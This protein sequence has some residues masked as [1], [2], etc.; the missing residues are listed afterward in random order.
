MSENTI[1]KKMIIEA[2]TSQSIIYAIINPIEKKAYIGE[3]SDSFR[4]LSEHIRGI[5]FRDKEMGTNENLA[6]ENCRTFHFMTLYSRNYDKHNKDTKKEINEWILYETIYMYLFK[7]SGFILYNGDN[8]QQDNLG[9]KRAFLLGN[10][11]LSETLLNERMNYFL[12]SGTKYSD[13]KLK[14]IWHKIDMC[15][16]SLDKKIKF[17][18]GVTLETLRKLDRRKTYALWEK[19]YGFRKNTFTMKSETKKEDKDI[20]YVIDISPDNNI[21]YINKLCEISCKISRKKLVKDELKVL[22]LKEK[23]LLEMAEAGVLDKIIVS[24]IG[25]Y[26]GQSIET[27][28]LTKM[29]DIYHNKLREK[30]K[31]DIVC[32]DKVSR[33]DGICFWSLK[34]LPLDYTRDFIEKGV[35]ES[36][37][38]SFYVIMPYVDSKPPKEFCVQ[39]NDLKNYYLLNP[40]DNEDLETFHLRIQDKINQIQ[41]DKETDQLS[42]KD[43]TLL[44]ILASKYAL[45]KE[46]L[47]SLNAKDY[48][49]RNS[50]MFPE[51]LNKKSLNVAFLVSELS[52][53]KEDF[54]D[55]EFYKYFLSKRGGYK[56][57]QSKTLFESIGYSSCCHMCAELNQKE[58]LINFLKNCSYNSKFTGCIIAK[59]EYPYIVAIK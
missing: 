22:N 59:I 7:K 39:E 53:S 43:K 20:V 10:E 16:A 38:E 26:L 19:K 5:G 33:D 24:K 58:N 41:A 51:V 8:R 32:K 14:E 1:T 4:R 40:H 29:Y 15:S 55:K 35:M 13:D 46:D 27:I 50:K 23:S 2:P 54:D 11:L 42:G 47:D 34:N 37:Q 6:N 12:K 44:G 52:Y 48:P 45:S 28:L 36:S 30:G 3:T 57:S 9:K 17:R 31:I 56:P 21:K 25:H 18:Y 49:G